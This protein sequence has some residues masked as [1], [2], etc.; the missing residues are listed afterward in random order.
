MGNFDMPD[1]VVVSILE[2]K[3]QDQLHCKVMAIG[4]EF[5][6]IYLYIDIA[7]EE[8]LPNISLII[9]HIRSIQYVKCLKIA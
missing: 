5:S 3:N 4:M 1:S 2:E 9:I 8:I 7:M 6:R